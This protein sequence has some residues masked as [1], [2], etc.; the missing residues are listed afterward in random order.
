MLYQR[1]A[2]GSASVEQWWLYPL[3]PRWRRPSPSTSDHRQKFDRSVSPASKAPTPTVTGTDQS[4]S[5]TEGSRRRK[6]S[7]TLRVR[8]SPSTAVKNSENKT[9]LPPTSS[10]WATLI[11]SPGIVATAPA[12]NTA[13]VA[14]PGCH[15]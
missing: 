13:N 2:A 15:L 7:C 8:S 10:T 4:G 3:A 12:A 6:T 9:L 5:Y 14:P 11:Q 1:S